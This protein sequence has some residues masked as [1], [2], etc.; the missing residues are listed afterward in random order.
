MNGPFGVAA[1]GVGNVYLADFSNKRIQRFGSSGNFLRAGGED[2][3]SAGP[4]NTGTGYE[5]C[6]AA[7]GDTCKIGVAGGSV[8][9]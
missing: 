9:K 7:N 3:A 8:A 4:G 5:I 2:V 1:D 6:V